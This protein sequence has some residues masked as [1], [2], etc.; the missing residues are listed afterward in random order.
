MPLS[1]P[2]PVMVATLAL[3]GVLGV[4]HRYVTSPL[5]P[6]LGRAFGVAYVGGS[7]VV[8]PLSDRHGRLGVLVGGLATGHFAHS[9]SSP[10]RTR[11][12][13]HAS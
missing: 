7:L 12:A 1:S 6:I 2:V 4:S 13:T 10:A 3:C 8:G 5:A 11:A 9:C